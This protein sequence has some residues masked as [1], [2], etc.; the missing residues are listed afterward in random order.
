MLSC[1]GRRHASL[2]ARWFHQVTIA[3]VRSEIIEEN[4]LDVIKGAYFVF[5]VILITI[6][7]F[8]IF[9]T[10][11]E[12]SMCTPQTAFVEVNIVFTVLCLSQDLFL[13]NDSF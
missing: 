3:H 5:L 11:Y 6:T 7:A 13:F 9:V 1:H 12:T 8:V 2:S 10:F 4:F